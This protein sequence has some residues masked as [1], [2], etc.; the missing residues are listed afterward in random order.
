MLWT[1][2]C[3]QLLSLP[4]SQISHP[5]P[6]NFEITFFSHFFPS[7]ESSLCCAAHVEIGACS[8]VWSS[9]QRSHHYINKQQQQQKLNSPPPS[10]CQ[11]IIAAQLVVGLYVHLLS[12]MLEFC[13]VWNCKRFVHVVII[14]MSS[15]IHL[16][17][18][19]YKT[20]SPWSYP[21]LFALTDFRPPFPQRTLKVPFRTEH[22][23]VFCSLSTN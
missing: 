5:F 13:L 10:C 6:L 3:H 15:D 4:P 18:C 9:Y 22:S 12:S 1:Y 8:A 17:C 7:S 2:P 16:P 14:S 19:V 23:V 21:P 11:G 20:L